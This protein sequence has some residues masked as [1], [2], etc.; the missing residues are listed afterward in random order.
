M[1][2]MNDETA[3]DVLRDLIKD[4]PRGVQAKL[5]KHMHVKPQTI[6]KWLKGEV[7]PPVERWLDIE[8]FFEVE[9]FTIAKRIGMFDRWPDLAVMEPSRLVDLWR[10]TAP[11]PVDDTGRRVYALETRIIRLEDDAKALTQQ[12]LRLER[13]LDAGARRRPPGATP[14]DQGGEQAPR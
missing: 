9:R 10:I 7:I 13:L 11:P 3:S 1:P 5:A 2:A 4:Y 14:D 12:V 8:D 6:T